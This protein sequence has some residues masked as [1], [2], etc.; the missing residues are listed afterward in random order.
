MAMLANFKSKAELTRHVKGMIANGD[1]DA[2]LITELLRFHPNVRSEDFEVFIRTNPTFKQK[3]IAIKYQTGEVHNPS[4]KTCVALAFD[5][6]EAAMSRIHTAKVFRAARNAIHDKSRQTYM[7]IHR[8]CEVCQSSDKLEADH[9][10]NSF[11]QLFKWWLEEE[12]L[13]HADV[14][15]KDSQ[16]VN[17]GIRCSWV[18]FHEE[19]VRW[20]ALCI[21]CH[22]KVTALSRS[23]EEGA[24]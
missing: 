2:P 7:R 10:I 4:Y 18:D 15:V 20:K 12:E 19:H 16:I 21:P 14:E 9:F 17:A 1:L 6:S 13:R 11:H 8:K 22:K 3:E 23:H 5:N 24:R